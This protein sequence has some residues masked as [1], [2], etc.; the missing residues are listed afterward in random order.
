MIRSRL[1][2]F[3]QKDTRKL[4]AT[5][6]A[7][8][9]IGLMTIIGVMKGVSWYFETSAHAAPLVRQA[10]VN[11]DQLVSSANTVW[12]LVT[13][14]LVFFMQAG[15]MGL[16]AGFARSR[17]TVNVL[18]ECVF[19]T[20]LC[21]LLY[22]AIG[23]AFQFGSGNGLIGHEY[24]FLHGMTPAYKTSSVAFLA[25]FLFQ[26]AFA[27]TASTVT[28]GAMVGRTGF[29]GDIIYSTLVS[30]FFYPIFGHWVWGPGGWLGN[31][32]GWFH[33]LAGGTV[34]RDFAGSTV[35]H[36][37]GGFIALAGCIVLGPRLG[38]VF[39]RDG[40]GPLAPH[41][42]TWGAIGGVI[43]WFGW[44]GFNP[45]STLSAM[46]W[47]GIGRVAANTT[48]A[49]CG[50]GMMA[51][52]FVYRKTK[53]WDLSISV[54]GF[55]GG[56]V[57]ITCPCY[58]V[59]PFGAIVIGAVAGIVV[60]LGMDFMEWRR[61]DDPIGAV[62]VHGFAGIWGT[63]SLGLLATGQYGI[64][65][66]TGTDTS[67][68]VTGLFYGGGTA[69]LRSQFIGSMTCVVVVGGLALLVMKLIKMIPGSWTLRVSR[70][71]ELEGLDLHEH[72]TAA[73]HVE[74]GQGMTYSAPPNLSPRNGAKEPV[75]TQ[76]ETID[77][78]SSPVGP[79]SSPV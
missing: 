2:R 8:K 78:E 34:F 57:A 67:T 42:L 13:A 74:F 45:G 75:V 38:R 24:F 20:C 47:V 4:I 65:T 71:G 28:S 18:L 54:N 50:G 5:I 39:K 72:G 11:T 30:G 29:K 15:F 51:V 6:M 9:M 32:M 66:P 73:Y 3:K 17:E 63:L 37:V 35:V 22:W 27:D 31:T 55:L 1:Q 52:L 23:F 60:P 76:V 46:D 48:L 12:V 56:L 16:E 33:G 25:F 53:I 49:A 26:F 70:D 19:D 41:D 68:V 79:E 59:S 64:P 43:L 21:G 77:P 7:G 36:T 14:F 61:W 69:Q 10:A 62:A 44:Y 58:W 40:G